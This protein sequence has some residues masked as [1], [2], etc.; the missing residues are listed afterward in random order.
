MV[1]V[2][3]DSSQWFDMSPAVNDTGHHIEGTAAAATYVARYAA[4]LQVWATACVPVAGCHACH[5]QTLYWLPVQRLACVCM[6]RQNAVLKMER[7]RGCVQM[8]GTHDA[9]AKNLAGQPSMVSHVF[10]QF[11][12]PFV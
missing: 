1:R 8:Q 4:M 3:V 9:V 10:F 11:F 7:D 6:A 2:Q 12:P 5:G